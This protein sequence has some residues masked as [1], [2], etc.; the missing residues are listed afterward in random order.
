[1]KCA[2]FFS[3][4]NARPLVKTTV[5]LSAASCGPTMYIAA[6]NR[7]TTSSCCFPATQSPGP[8]LLP[9]CVNQLDHTGE[10]LDDTSSEYVR[11]VGMDKFFGGGQGMNG[12][13]S[14]NDLDGV[15][16]GRGFVSISIPYASQ[17]TE[18]D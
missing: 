1:M 17:R 6:R 13:Y 9:S 3:R 7:N 18:S 11:T 2:L 8:T 15:E 5:V 14:R 10:G 16:I 12:E 4:H